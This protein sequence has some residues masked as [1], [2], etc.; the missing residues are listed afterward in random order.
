MIGTE[1]QYIVY[2]DG[3]FNCPLCAF[4]HWPKDYAYF[5]NKYGNEF[6]IRC[7]NTKQCRTRLMVIV[8]GNIVKVTTKAWDEA[9]KRNM[10]PKRDYNNNNNKTVFTMKKINVSAHA[11]RY[12]D[13]ET[14][15]KIELI[16][17][18]KELVEN[19]RKAKI[20]EMEEHIQ[21]LK[22][23]QFPLKEKPADKQ[24]LEIPTQNEPVPE[25]TIEEP[26][27]Q[28]ETTQEEAL[29]NL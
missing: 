21:K 4:V 8:D 12:V 2:D 20:I 5:L 28:T 29:S 10:R 27:D 9:F 23:G 17:A 7:L 24:Q 3:T 22:S 26:T 11:N 18:L 1:N 14:T 13:V 15:D 19:D 16:E 6:Q 25:N